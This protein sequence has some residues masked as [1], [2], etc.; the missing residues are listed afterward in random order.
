LNF[1]FYIARRLSLSDNEKKTDSSSAIYPAIGA[2]ALGIAVMIISLSVV[3]GFNNEIHNKVTGF[4]SHITLKNKSLNISDDAPPIAA[5]HPLLREIRL[6]P[7]VNHTQSFVL[8]PGIIKTKSEIQGII[9][10]GYDHDFDSSFFKKNLISGKIPN[11]SDSTKS[12]EVLISQRIAKLM[13]IKT[14]DKLPVY[15]IQSP[16]RVRVFKI[17]GIFRTDLEEFDR[18]FAL[19]DMRQLQKLNNWGDSLVSGYEIFI[20]DFSKIDTVSASLDELTTQYISPQGNLP[21]IS[22]VKENFP[23]IFDWLSLSD[24]NILVIIILMLIVAVFN[25]IS[26]L[27]IIILEKTRTIGVLKSLGASNR[28][29]RRIFL[30]NGL[31]LVIKGIVPGNILA[32]SLL[33][34]QDAF[35]FLTLDPDSYYI[36]VVPVIFSL[37]QIVYLNLGTLLISVIF[38]TLPTFMIS[39]TDTI[40]IIQFD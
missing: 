4:A 23:Y 18:T 8:K 39:K 26:G 31:F 5:N 10:K 20:R 25:L 2:V 9:M 13:K 36:S 14:G 34:V 38:M 21:D 1:I 17:S 16:P 22:S 24:M 28:K 27:L 11:L 29:L 12:N 30:L 40:K 33:W 37:K 15:F 6:N 7:E 19:C 35:G 3:T 32:L